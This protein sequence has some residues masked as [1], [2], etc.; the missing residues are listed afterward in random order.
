[1]ARPDSG[2]VANSDSIQGRRGSPQDFLK[3][4]KFVYLPPTPQNYA[5]DRCVMIDT[6]VSMSSFQFGMC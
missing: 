3:V 5:Y 6:D 2:L 1:M 4:G